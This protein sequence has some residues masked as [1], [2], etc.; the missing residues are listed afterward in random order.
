MKVDEIA[1]I[2]FTLSNNLPE[3]FHV[4]F[5]QIFSP[6]KVFISALIKHFWATILTHLFRS[7]FKLRGH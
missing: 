5:S 7:N 4:F 6:R 1:V 3:K 2:N